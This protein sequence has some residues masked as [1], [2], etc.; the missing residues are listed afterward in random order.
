LIA[1]AISTSSQLTDYT[2]IGR[3]ANLGARIC[4]VATPKQ[5]LINQATYDQVKD[6]VQATPVPG[7]KLRGV[8][9]PVT[10]YHVLRLESTSTTFGGV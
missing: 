1:S 7:L 9:Q 4:S 10:A 2:V 6:D 8:E 5:V 3:A